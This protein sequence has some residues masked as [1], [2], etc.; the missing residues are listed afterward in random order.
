[1]SEK[2]ITTKLRSVALKLSLPNVTNEHHNNWNKIHNL[3]FLSRQLTGV[4]YILMLSSPKRAK[5]F[6]SALHL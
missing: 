1:M 2:Q 3:R 5:Y 6:P 4:S